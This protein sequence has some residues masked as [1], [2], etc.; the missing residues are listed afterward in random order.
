M[1]ENAVETDEGE[2]TCAS[3][4][5]NGCFAKVTAHLTVQTAGHERSKICDTKKN[6]TCTW[7]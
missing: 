3:T 5:A 7:F 6:D 2:Y 1:I 4:D